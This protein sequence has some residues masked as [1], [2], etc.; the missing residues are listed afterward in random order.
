MP[1]SEGERVG[2]Y[3]VISRIAAGGVGEVWK[4]RDT[5]LNREVALK[6]SRAAFSKRFQQEARSTHTRCRSSAEFFISATK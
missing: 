6:T 4:A 1:L 5:L 3:E 2:P